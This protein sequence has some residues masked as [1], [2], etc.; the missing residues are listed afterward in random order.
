MKKLFLVATLALLAVISAGCDAENLSLDITGPDAMKKTTGAVYA[1]T[2]TGATPIVG[3]VEYWWYLDDNDD[4][5]PQAAEILKYYELD[6]DL[7]G[8]STYYFKWIPDSSIATELPK[9]VVLSLY[10]RVWSP[11]TNIYSI[12]RDSIEVTIVD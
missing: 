4:E 8:I 9:D 7:D 1:G 10:V 11:G 5:F 6:A 2:V 12:L 3:I